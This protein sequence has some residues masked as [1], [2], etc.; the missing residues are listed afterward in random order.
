MPPARNRCLTAVLAVLILSAAAPAVAQTT[1]P[2][3]EQFQFNFSSPGARARAMGGAFIGVADD[4]TAAVTNP[5]GL[6]ALTK[7]QVYFEFKTLPLETTRLAK[8]NSFFSLESTLFLHDSSF[9]S[10]VSFAAPIG[11]R[12]AI[13][14]SR[15][16][17]LYLQEFFNYEPRVSHNGS[18][19][20]PLE[21]QSDFRGASY[22]GS[23]AM[24][25]GRGI[26]MGVTVSANRLHASASSRAFQFINTPSGPVA[27][28]TVANT[29]V[30][31]PPS[32]SFVQTSASVTVGMLYR[33]GPRLAVGAFYAKP[34]QFT[35]EE[36]FLNAANAALSPARNIPIHLP[37]RFGGGVSVRPMR[38]LLIAADVERILYSQLLKDFVVGPGNAA[39]LTAANYRISNTLQGRVGAELTVKTGRTQVFARAGFV[40]SPDHRLR[41][42]PTDNLSEFTIA[43]ETDKFNLLQSSSATGAFGFGVTIARRVQFDVALAWTGETISSLMVRF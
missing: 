10:F 33:P 16:Q 43:G 5:A 31:G 3:F 21:A 20:N 40:R 18:T 39:S 13:S 11:N 22:A 4:A 1:A 23:V 38:R 8:S 12:F 36:K 30:Y 41:F 29:L 37:T 26:R 24:A 27:T 34:P 19:F 42:V 7:P 17:F 14:V 25:L 2:N 28:S 32:G 9:F 15:H 6:L 35:L